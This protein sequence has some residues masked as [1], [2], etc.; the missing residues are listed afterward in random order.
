MKPFFSVVIPTYN[1]GDLLKKC[2]ETVVKQSFKNYEVIVIDNHS[3]DNTQKIIKKFKKKIIYKKI[4][5]RGVI[6]RSRNYG[7][8]KSNGKLR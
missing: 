4:K 1:Q 6:A 8:K 3:N 5:N 2:L 7:I